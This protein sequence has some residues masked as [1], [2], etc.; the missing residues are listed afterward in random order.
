MERGPLIGQGRTA[1][2]YAWGQDR[3]LKLY[4]DWMPLSAVEREYAITRTAHAAGLPVPATEQLVEVEGRHGIVFER[5]VGPSMLAELETRPW[6]IFA[7][8][9]RLGELHAQVHDC[10]AP[11]ELPSQRRQIENGIQAAKD[12]PEADKEALRCYLAELP[13]GDTLCHGDFHPDNIMMTA[14]GPVIIDWMTGTRGH[15]LADVARTALLFHTGGLPPGTPLY[16]RALSAASR[17]LMYRQYLKR[18]FKYHPASPQPMDAWDLPLMAARLCEVE[19]YPREKRL[20][21]KRLNARL[22]R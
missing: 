13:E 2:I 16:L 1:E 5:L 14:R 21:L 22:M 17:S 6:R 12:L 9:R 3:V 15:P 10:T 18:Y 20:I 11:P 8:S 19:G 7:V 4:Q